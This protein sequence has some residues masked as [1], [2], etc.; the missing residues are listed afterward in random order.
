[1]CVNFNCIFFRKSMQLD[2][3][4]N[5]KNSFYFRSIFKQNV[6][7]VRD[8]C[9]IFLILYAINAYS[10]IS[11]IVATASSPSPSIDNTSNAHPN[12]LLLLSLVCLTN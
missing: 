8:K 12:S 11:L 6:L 7:N 2:L 10:L 5:N 3:N 4:K 1:M 9:V